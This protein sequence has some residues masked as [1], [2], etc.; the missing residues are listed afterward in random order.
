MKMIKPQ[1]HKPLRARSAYYE[2]KAKKHET[3]T[4]IEY[5]EICLNCTEKKCLRECD[6]VKGVR[7]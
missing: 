2:E 1:K 4:S 3:N 7:R 6:K 5:I